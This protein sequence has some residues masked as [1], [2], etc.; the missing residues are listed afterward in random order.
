M[1]HNPRVDLCLKTAKKNE[2]IWKNL[3]KLGF[4][5][6]VGKM[7]KNTKMGGS[8]GAWWGRRAGGGAVGGGE[9]MGGSRAWWVWILG[10]DW[11][12]RTVKEGERGVRCYS[13][14]GGDR[15]KMT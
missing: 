8:G 6:F 14:N 15:R 5:F 12:R 11:R 13:E 9:V 7:G 1:G 2:K 4:G 10:S 3:K